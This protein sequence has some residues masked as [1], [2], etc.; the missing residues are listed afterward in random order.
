MVPGFR[1]IFDIS[2]DDYDL[3]KEVEPKMLTT[4]VVHPNNQG[5]ASTMSKVQHRAPVK[6]GR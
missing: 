6:Y 3:E 2:H 5:L 4:F 1:E